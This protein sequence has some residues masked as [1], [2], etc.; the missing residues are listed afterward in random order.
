MPS[1]LRC[2]VPK[3]LQNIPIA[4]SHV[5]WN[6]TAAVKRFVTTA[7]CQGMLEEI[8]QNLLDETSIAKSPLEDNT[9]YV[10]IVASNQA[11]CFNC[12]VPGHVS[13]SCPEPPRQR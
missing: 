10:T 12:G 3:C 11:I 8:V 2:C 13:R 6:N 7:V 4:N 5:S 1:A 9:A